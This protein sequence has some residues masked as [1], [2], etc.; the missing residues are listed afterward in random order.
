MQIDRTSGMSGL[1]AKLR[2]IRAFSVFLTVLG[3]LLASLS[4]VSQKEGW[5]WLDQYNLG[6]ILAIGQR[7]YALFDSENFLLHLGGPI[8]I[9]G[10]HLYRL[11]HISKAE[12]KNCEPPK[13]SDHAGTTGSE[14]QTENAS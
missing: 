5:K 9:I 14:H 2:R 4:A 11:C 8:F 13:N 10:V 7:I 3:L 6:D 12:L 1:C